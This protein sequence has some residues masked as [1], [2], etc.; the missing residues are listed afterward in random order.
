[1]AELVTDCPRCGAT[2][3]TFDLESQHFLYKKYDWKGYYE[4]FSICRNCDR[5]TVFVLSI[6]D[7]QMG[8]HVANDGLIKAGGSVNN[9]MD[10]EGF[11]NL[12]NM[13]ASQPPEHLPEDIG[14]AFTEGA[15]C[16]GVE[17]FNAAGTMFRLCVDLATRPLLPEK[18]ENGLNSRI[19]R[20]L[21]LRL[22]WLFDNSLLPSALR[23][24]SACIKED[25]NDGAH[26]GNLT[27]E[28]AQDLLEFAYAFLERVYTEPGR[29]RIASERRDSRRKPKS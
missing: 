6:S 5:T 7:I 3:I 14:A 1:M 29:L 10:V 9:Y 21:G 15:T 23:D 22:P 28:D 13:A 11:I 20:N 19:R 27:K 24:L 17:C 2:K 18:D 12:K 4:V 26:A 8:Q 25:G 16:L